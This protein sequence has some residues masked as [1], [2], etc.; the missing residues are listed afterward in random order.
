[1]KLYIFRHGET[2]ANVINLIQGN[3]DLHGLNETGIL[4]AENCVTNSVPPNFRSYTA[5]RCPGRA[6]PPR[7]LPRPTELRL[8]LSTACMKSIWEKPRASMKKKPQK[9]MAAK[10]LH[11]LK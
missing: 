6:K 1:M 8:K 11:L 9:Y 3:V 10:F 4:Q 2:E 7:S 5:V